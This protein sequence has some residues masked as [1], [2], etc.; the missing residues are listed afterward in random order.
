MTTRGGALGLAGLGVWIVTPVVAWSGIVPLGERFGGDSRSTLRSLALIAALLG[1]GAWSGNIVL[2]A[3][4]A[5]IERAWD[6]LDRLYRAHRRTGEA[7]VVLLVLHGGLILSSLGNLS[8]FDV[9]TGAIF[10]GPVIL[11]ALITL[12]VVSVYGRL[13]RDPFVWIQRALGFLFLLGLFHVFGVS[14]DKSASQ[15]L[16]AVLAFYAAVAAAAWTYRSVLGRRVAPR[17]HYTVAAMRPITERITEVVL[18]PVDHPLVFA[19]GQFAFL[20]LGAPAHDTKPHPFSITSAPGSLQLRF[21]VKGVGDHTRELARIPA[22]TSARVE[23]PYGALTLDRMTSRR[24]VWIGGGIGITPFLG[25][26]R[27]VRR[28]EGRYDIDLYYCTAHAEEA[29]FHDEL[30]E[31]VRVI[32]VQEDTDGFLTADRIAATSGPLGGDT[33]YLICGPPAMLHSLRSQLEASG[34]PGHR[35]HAEDFTFRRS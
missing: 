20:S 11:A 26:A 4:I 6:G 18:D 22:G 2:G 12:V 3:R 27:A 28:D 25:M 14:G 8:A 13:H 31:H 1:Y 15:T 7:T 9:E 16:T 23:G 19:P 34:V 30:A 32:P 33:D 10:L 17:H 24:Q 29:Y 21:V 5:P 35:V